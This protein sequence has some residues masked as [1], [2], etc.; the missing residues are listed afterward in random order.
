MKTYRK[1]AEFERKV[2]RSF[3][4]KGYSVIRGAGS[5]GSDLFVKEL[6]LSIECKALRNFAGYRLMNGSDA[7]VV[8]ANRKKP[9]VVIPLERFLELLKR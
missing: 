7:L 2:R 6:S 8:K 9:L 1:G 4:E 3:E 5:K